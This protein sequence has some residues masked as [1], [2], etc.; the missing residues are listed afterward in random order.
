[1]KKK[2]KDTEE[3]HAG[4]CD[5]RHWNEYHKKKIEEIKRL[6]HEIQETERFTK[7]L[8]ERYDLKS[9]D[10][11]QENI[12]QQGLQQTFDKSKE[13]ANR[14]MDLLFQSI[15]RSEYSGTFLRVASKH[16]LHLEALRININ[17]NGNGVL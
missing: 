13:G 16:I 10:I 15:S 12:I 4:L 11:S 5:E 9:D 14:K 7:P 8:Q 6:P 17:I 1:M 2:R 3:R